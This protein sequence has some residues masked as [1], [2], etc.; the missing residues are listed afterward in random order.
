M[1]RETNFEILKIDSEP[2]KLRLISDVY[3]IF[4][5][6]KY[7]PYVD[8]VVTKTKQRVS[9]MVSAQSIAQKLEDYREDNKRIE[10]LEIWLHKESDDK[11][12]KYVIELA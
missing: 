10:D 3:F 7:T 12:A 8:V 11:W 1:K 4:N 6:Y 2:K 9:V 5:S